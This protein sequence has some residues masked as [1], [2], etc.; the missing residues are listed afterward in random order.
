MD[1]IE[2]LNVEHGITT[3]LVTHEMEVALRA[4]RVIRF[5]DGLVE[6][7]EVMT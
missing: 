6:K 2:Q 5:R 1:A 3:I 4:R 7:D